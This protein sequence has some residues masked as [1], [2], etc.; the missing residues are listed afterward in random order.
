MGKGF[1]KKAGKKTRLCKR[2]G[3]GVRFP[4]FR[5]WQQYCGDDCRKLAWW[6]R[7]G[8]T[9]KRTAR[10]RQARIVREFPPEVRDQRRTRSEQ[11]AGGS[12]AAAVRRGR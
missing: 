10:E 12:M 6:H 3:C 11:L 4:V 8:Q 2:V 1:H 9:E 7:T 5:D